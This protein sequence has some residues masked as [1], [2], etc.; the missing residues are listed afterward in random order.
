MSHGVD[1]LLAALTCAYAAHFAGATSFACY[2]FLAPLSGFSGWRR[3][4]KR[5]LPVG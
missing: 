4:I 1:F 3:K 5:E 2:V